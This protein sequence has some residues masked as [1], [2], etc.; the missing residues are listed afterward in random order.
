[1]TT[2][3]FPVIVVFLQVD[4]QAISVIANLAEWPLLL[5]SVHKPVLLAIKLYLLRQIQYVGHFGKLIFECFIFLAD[6]Q[7][8]ILKAFE[9]GLGF[10][11]LSFLAK[12]DRTFE[13]GCLVH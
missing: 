2:L 3:A 7:E 8:F 10:F 9:Q 1:M 6:R 12:N 4:E 5:P 11:Y 13:T